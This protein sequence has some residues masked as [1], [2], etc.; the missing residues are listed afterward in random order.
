MSALR[1]RKGDTEAGGLDHQL[2]FEEYHRAQSHLLLFV[3]PDRADPPST[4]QQA[5]TP[6][7]S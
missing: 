3:S 4:M 1:R 5:I 7:D 6:Q 2:L